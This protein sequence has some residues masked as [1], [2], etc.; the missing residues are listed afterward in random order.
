MQVPSVLADRYFYGRWTSSVLNLVQYNVFSREGSILYGVEGPLFYFRNGFN[1]FNFAFLIALLSPSLLL[2]SKHK[3]DRLVVAVSPIFLWLAFMT[4]QPH[5]EERLI[6]FHSQCIG[7]FRSC[8]SEGWY[9][10]V[11]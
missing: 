9:N 10:E 11:I 3:Y 6:P 7:S 2:L 5:K 4:L 8:I 1:N